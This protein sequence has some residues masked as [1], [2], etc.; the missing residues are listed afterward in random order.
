MRFNCRVKLKTEKNE[1]LIPSDYRKYISSLI[2][3]SFKLS[4]EGSDKF[5]DFNFNKNIQKPYT[6]SVYFPI[7]EYKEKFFILKENYFIL[8]FSSADY[9]F[10][11][12]IYN[13][14]LKIKNGYKIFNDKVEVENFNLNLKPD[15]AFNENIVFKT[16]SPILIRNPKDGDYYFIL[17]GLLNGKNFKYAI[18]VEEKELIDALKKNIEKIIEMGKTRQL[19]NIDIKDEIEIQ[20]IKLQLS[21]SAHSSNRSKF[22]MTL[23]AM[24]G[25]IK[26]KAPPEVLK[27]LY[28]T[29]IGARRS[30]GFGMVEVVK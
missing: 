21:P 4:G 11:L 28:D 26:L 24:K 7:K 15:Y 10:L 22:F 30:E 1:I 27:F 9:E 6:F 8:N 13:G 18:E 12:R 25:L 14:L 2:K 17:K 5:F 20:F 29:G 3:E 23:P 16:L 19:L